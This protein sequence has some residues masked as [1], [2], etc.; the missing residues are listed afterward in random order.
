[1][2][3]RFYLPGAGFVVLVAGWILVFGFLGWG[4]STPLLDRI[5]QINQRMEHA[6][7]QGLKDDEVADLEAAITR[8]PDLGREILGNRLVR[9]VEPSIKRWCA[10]PAQHLVF[11]EDW[12]ENQVL[13][14]D[15]D[16]APETFPMELRLVGAG[17]DNT[18]EF[19]APGPAVIPL[20][21][22]ERDGPVLVRTRLSVE[23]ADG[24][25]RG[26][27]FFAR[28]QEVAP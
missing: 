24:P 2:S 1:M 4:F 7:F 5:W 9:I 15:V 28:P 21:F 12:V 17:L 10:L 11:S 18:I 14:I 19:V 27:R 6:D 3:R 25:W 23:V 22:A 13:V 8:Y 16:F 26:L 20:S